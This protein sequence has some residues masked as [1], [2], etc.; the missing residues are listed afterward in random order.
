M[1]KIKAILT[2]THRDLHGDRLT[3]D[4]LRSL[5]EQISDHYIPSNYEHDI[6]IPPVGRTVSAEVV[7]LVDGEFALFVETEVWERGDSLETLQ[8][9][10][11]AIPVR[12]YPHET[13]SVGYDRMFSHGEGRALVDSLAELAGQDQAPRMTLKKSLDP[14][15][16]LEIHTGILVVGAIGA[17][18]LAKLGADIY[19]NLKKQLQSF[20]S[21][22]SD[23]DYILDFTLGVESADRQHE[24]H[25]LLSRPNPDD[26]EAF[27]DQR[28]EGLD[29]LV[30]QVLQLGTDTDI[31]RIVVEWAEGALK[32]K[33]AVRTDGV[34]IH[35]H[36]EDPE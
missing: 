27:F 26:L 33:Y 20:F 35:F 18:F 11:R 22:D 3:E 4:A 15:G 24:V 8:G 25:L 30:E 36:A 7:E 2:S 10:G 6:R 23:R 32:L 28:L 31:A 5:V 19:D 17:G 29:F 9:D 16:I 21:E 14:V 1:K 12:I 13:F 34:P